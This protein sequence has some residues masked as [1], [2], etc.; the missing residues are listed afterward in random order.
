[1]AD[2]RT[3][4]RF[5][6]YGEADGAIAPEFIHIEPISARSRRYQGTIAPHTHSGIFQFILLERGGGWLNA[7]GRAAQLEPSAL[8]AIPSGCVHAFHFGEDAEGWVLSIASALLG[9][10]RIGNRQSARGPAFGLAVALANALE[11]GAARRLS[12]L[13]GDLA[14]DFA[15]HGARRLSDAMLA[16]LALLVALG[17]EVLEP[18]AGSRGLPGGTEARR[19]RL[20]QRF[21]ALVDLHFREDWP[22]SRYA[23]ALGTSPPSLSRACQA[24]LGR[25]PGDVVQ[26]RRQLEAMRALTYTAASVRRIADDL[27]FAD[28]AYF[29]RFFK[30]RTGMTASRF[31]AERAWLEGH[32]SQVGSAAASSDSGE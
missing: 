5:S 29:A 23:A 1:M 28:P 15:R 32:G 6:L 12:W 3:F 31:R 18:G 21:R 14:A 30:A 7:D 13:L 17:D 11:P 27:G 25:A 2:S 9:E 26:D 20:V 22:V 10:L 8:V 16:A 24:V 19:D 4:S